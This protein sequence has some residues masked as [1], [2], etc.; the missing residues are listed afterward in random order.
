M[1]A[2]H[3]EDMFSQR[4]VCVLLRPAGAGQG[5]SKHLENIE[6]IVEGH[7]ETHIMDVRIRGGQ[8]HIVLPPEWGEGE[9]HALV[10]ELNTLVDDKNRPILEAE[11]SFFSGYDSGF[12]PREP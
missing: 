11:I 4:S 3:N 7:V 6:K 9:A 8:C 1:P 12:A 5:L 10:E 2:W